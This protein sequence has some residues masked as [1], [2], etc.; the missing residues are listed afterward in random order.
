MNSGK[1]EEKKGEGK[2]EI[3]LRLSW[4]GKW[5][6]YFE[7]IAFHLFK[8]G[9]IKL[10]HSFWYLATLLLMLSSCSCFVV[11]AV[12]WSASFIFCGAFHAKLFC[13]YRVLFIKLCKLSV[14]DEKHTKKCTWWLTEIAQER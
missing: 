7:A 2:W 14:F 9:G 4:C 5:A 3:M 10:H 13:L 6:P 8:A 11:V 12:V 1:T